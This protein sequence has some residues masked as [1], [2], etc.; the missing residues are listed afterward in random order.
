MGRRGHAWVR[1][2]FAWKGIAE[3]MHQVYRWLVQPDSFPRPVDV[4]VD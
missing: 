4:V 2:E 3:R 1:A